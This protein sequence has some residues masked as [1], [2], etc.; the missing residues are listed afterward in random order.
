MIRLLMHKAKSPYTQFGPFDSD[1]LLAYKLQTI[2][3]Y[4]PEVIILGSSRVMHYRSAFFEDS[5]S[6]YNASSFGWGLNR[7]KTI[8][9]FVAELEKP[10]QIVIIGLDQWRFQERWVIPA[11]DV[12]LTEGASQS[13]I[14]D[15]IGNVT[16]AMIGKG[17]SPQSLIDAIVPH[18]NQD[19]LGISAILGAG[20]YIYDGSFQIAP[21]IWAEAQSNIKIAAEGITRSDETMFKYFPHAEEL[22]SIKY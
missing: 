14:W 17:A 10:P 11:D 6:V 7:Y 18:S 4:Q 8:V 22:A 2:E 3:R 5:D 21:E 15:G 20:G 12:P 1:R 19:A 16:N 13:R 9:E